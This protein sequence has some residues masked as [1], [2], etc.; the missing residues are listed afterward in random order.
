MLEQDIGFLPVARNDRLVGALTDRDIVLR[1]V[2]EGRDP[3]ETSV[4][5]IMTPGTK[6]C[7]ADEDA[8]HVV[9]NMA[10][11]HVCRLPVM[12]RR[13]RLVGV[14]SIDNLMP[15]LPHRD[16]DPRAFVAQP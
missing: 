15:Q 13:K 4:G 2:A 16:G 10:E 14:V 12:D 11:I 3:G 5:E 9:E 6:Y 8:G 7:Y 1:V